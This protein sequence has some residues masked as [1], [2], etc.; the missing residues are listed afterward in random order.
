MLDSRRYY[1]HRQNSRE[2]L[3]NQDV[4]DHSQG[5]F[6]ACLFKDIREKRLGS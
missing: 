6:P 3:A 5:N 4:S 2:I 1:L